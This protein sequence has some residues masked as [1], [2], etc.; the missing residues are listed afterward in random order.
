MKTPIEDMWQSF[1]KEVMPPDVSQTQLREM[2]KAFFSGAAGL[3][4]YI[5]NILEPGKEATEKDL[6]M[7]D[8]ISNELNDFIEIVTK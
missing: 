6:I 5:I 4:T 7:M 8:D 2:R 1:S 3:F